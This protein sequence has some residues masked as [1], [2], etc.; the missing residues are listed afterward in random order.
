MKWLF[1]I[2]LGA[3]LFFPKILPQKDIRSVSDVIINNP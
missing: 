3:I 1:L 2:T